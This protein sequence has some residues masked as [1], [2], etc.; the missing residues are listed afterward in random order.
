MPVAI[1][2]LPRTDAL[3][4]RA[5]AGGRLVAAQR[6]L[7]SR[8]S[9]VLLA[10]SGCFYADPINQRPSLDIHQTTAGDV[11]RGDTV[12]LEAVYNDP[13]GQLVYPTWRAYL[14]SD[15]TT[16]DGQPYFGGFDDRF[17]FTVPSLRMDQ[18]VP[19]RALHILLE[20]QDTFGATAKPVQQL[21][22]GVRDRA[23][24]LELQT[25]NRYGGVVGTPIDFYAKVGDPDDWPAV[26]TLAWTV[27]SPSNQPA[28]TFDDITVPGT[29]GDDTHVQFG[30]RLV[31]QGIGDFTIEVTATDSGG[32]TLTQMQT[33]KVG[34]DKP[35]CLSSLSPIVAPTGSALPIS[36]PTLFQVHVVSDDL[37]PYPTIADPI[38]GTT[39]FK[40]FLMPPGGTTHQLLNG[41]TGSGFAIDPA[42]YQPGD[43]VELRVEIA[44]RN[45]TPIT[46]ADG[47]ATCSVVSDNACIQRQT[48]R[49]EVR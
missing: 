36:E 44:D 17:V 34:V 32:E 1:T 20:G 38:L 8:V 5:L 4:I 31:S 39:K 9:L 12:E 19:V 33:V 16:C 10:A 6:K 42:S 11:Y 23:P 28:Y 40:W 24:T 18:K 41:V 49:V 21:W 43:I 13:D 29:P 46:C 37:D 47:N 14:C 2:A 27:Y 48:W 30:K 45:N 25:Y 3:V 7:V 15:E 26:P 22:I 35:P